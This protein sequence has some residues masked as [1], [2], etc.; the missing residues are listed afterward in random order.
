MVGGQKLRYKDI[1]K[2]NLKA[3]GGHVT[4]VHDWEELA[5]DQS[6]YREMCRET[7]SKVDQQRRDN[8]T[9]QPTKDDITHRQR[10]LQCSARTVRKYAEEELDLLR[11]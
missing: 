3:A 2:R 6:K 1:L 9:L 5:R 7:I 4:H 8:Y 11:T 10:K